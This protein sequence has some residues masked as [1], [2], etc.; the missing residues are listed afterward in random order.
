[1]IAAAVFNKSLTLSAHARQKFTQGH[2]VNLMQLDA[3]KVEMAA[4]N[5][6]TLVDGV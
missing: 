4:S 2:M 6:F 5:G 3:T 1:M